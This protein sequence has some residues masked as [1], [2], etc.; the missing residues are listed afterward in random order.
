MTV[1]QVGSL[2]F[3]GKS[4][5]YLEMKSKPLIKVDHAQRFF[6]SKSKVRIKCKN[7][8]LVFIHFHEWNHTRWMLQRLFSNSSQKGSGLWWCAKAFKECNDVPCYDWDVSETYG[9]EVWQAG[10]GSVT[11]RPAQL[12]LA[13]NYLAQQK[14]WQ[15]SSLTNTPKQLCLFLF[16]LLQ[17]AVWAFRVFTRYVSTCLRWFVLKVCFSFFFIVFTQ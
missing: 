6:A 4:V 9:G 1:F 17:P 15:K 16:Y 8:E 14:C 11:S 10:G 5:S 12:R 3:R 13:N 7:L 2:S